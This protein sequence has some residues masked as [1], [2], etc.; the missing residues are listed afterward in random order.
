MTADQ[1]SELQ[2]RIS[3]LENQVDELEEIVVQS[4]DVDAVGLG[5][6]AE[7]AISVLATYVSEVADGFALGESFGVSRSS[8]VQGR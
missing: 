3:Q 5:R 4:E 2:Q 1:I 6:G 8:E 7:Q